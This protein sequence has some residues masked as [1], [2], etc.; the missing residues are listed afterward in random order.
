M[1]V[2]GDA[3]SLYTGRNMLTNICTCIYYVYLCLLCFC[4][5]SFMY[6]YSYLLLMYGLLPPSE[7]SIAVNNND[8]RPLSDVGATLYI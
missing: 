3:E 1:C 7:N 8:N 2:Q 4:I 5:V 6:I